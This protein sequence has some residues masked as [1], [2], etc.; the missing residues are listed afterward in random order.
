MR[1]KRRISHCPVSYRTPSW[2][3]KT[4]VGCNVYM[5]NRACH[6]AT[7][8]YAKHET[9]RYL[10]GCAFSPINRELEQNVE[11]V[12]VHNEEAEEE[13]GLSRHRS[14]FYEMLSESEP[15]CRIVDTIKLVK[16]YNL[17]GSSSPPVYEAFQRKF[18][19]E[20]VFFYLDKDIYSAVTHEA[21]IFIQSEMNLSA[22]T[23]EQMFHYMNEIG[24]KYSFNVVPR[25]HGKTHAMMIILL[26]VCIGMR[27]MKCGYFC[28]RLSLLHE[29]FNNLLHH[30]FEMVVFYN[31]MRREFWDLPYR[32]I[33]ITKKTNAYLR[34]KEGRYESKIDFIVVRDNKVSMNI[35]NI[36]F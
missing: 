13:E 12:L 11:S 2:I 36:T 23:G 6:S 15:M 30:A 17:T 3:R 18:F 19:L 35:D 14:S 27:D 1:R 8:K 33:K 26:T 29:I 32:Q 21:L 4:A 25:R 16:L 22:L 20:N 9:E 31:D 28:H 10:I 24:N 5:E 34:F 7:V